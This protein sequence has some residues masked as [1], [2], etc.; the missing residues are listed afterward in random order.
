MNTGLF[1][2]TL[3]VE[4]SDGRIFTTSLKIAE[5]FHKRHDKVME[6]I[7]RVIEQSPE[8]ESLPNFRER[9]DEYETG[10]KHNAK[11]TRTIFELTHDGFAVVAMSFTGEQAMQWKW[12]F[13]RA[14]RQMERQL[15]AVKERE[16]AAL[17]AIRPRWKPIVEH[18]DYRRADLIGLTGHKSL[19]S[20]T[21]CRRRMREVGLLDGRAA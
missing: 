21:A 14:F 1:P 13:L 7:R 19:G 17:Y 12:D 2:E 15:A 16:S 8:A 10:G 4:V 18:P 9:L 6:V 5:R 3:L 11:R 20:I